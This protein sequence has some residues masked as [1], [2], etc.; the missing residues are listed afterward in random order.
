M[1][2]NQLSSTE[3]SWTASMDEDKLIEEWTSLSSPWCWQSRQ[4]FSVSFDGDNTIFNLGCH[5]TQ[6]ILLS[7]DVATA[8]SHSTY[9]LRSQSQP[10]ESLTSIPPSASLT[11]QSSVLMFHF[12][13]QLQLSCLFCF[14]VVPFVLCDTVIPN[15]WLDIG[16]RIV[17]DIWYL[18]FSVFRILL[19][20]IGAFIVSSKLDF[21][22][23]VFHPKSRKFFHLVA[24]QVCKDMMYKI[25]PFLRNLISSLRLSRINI[26]DSIVYFLLYFK[27]QFIILAKTIECHRI[28]FQIFVI[29]NF[30]HC[31]SLWYSRQFVQNRSLLWD[32]NINMNRGEKNNQ[33]VLHPLFP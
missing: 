25:L 19:Q 2:R 8:I 16:Y 28:Q 9:Q 12:G 20:K 30:N 24:I 22:T 17:S 11:A 4:N 7:W 5:Q 32:F 26:C 14:F 21:R 18:C 29:G 6:K 10:I 15:T 3:T 31:F 1:L 13:Q 27:K 33:C 23:A